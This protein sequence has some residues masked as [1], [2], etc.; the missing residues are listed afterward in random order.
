MGDQIED[1]SKQIIFDQPRYIQFKNYI[2]DKIV[3]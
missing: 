3:Q 1:N 2:N